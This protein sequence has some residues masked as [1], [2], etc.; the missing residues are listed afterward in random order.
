SVDSIH[1]HVVIADVMYA[2]SLNDTSTSGFPFVIA[3]TDRT[4]EWISSPPFALVYDFSDSP[5]STTL[6][7]GNTIH[8]LQSFGAYHTGQEELAEW[9][10]YSPEIHWFY[11]TEEH[12]ITNLPT[13]GSE[14]WTTK[15]ISA[16]V[17]GS[18]VTNEP[19][20][21]TAIVNCSV[22]A[23]GTMLAATC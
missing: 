12:T 4:S 16:S 20:I 11:S 3:A 2:F 9:A 6:W 7:M 18:G 8:L 23:N 13:E 5:D 1:R 19:S 22:V 14:W 17:V 15:L 10:V 21:A